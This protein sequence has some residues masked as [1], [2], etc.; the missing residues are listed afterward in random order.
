MN[1]SGP[2][3]PTNSMAIR[4][5]TCGTAEVADILFLVGESWS[6]GEGNF[7][8]IKDFVYSVILS[9]ENV[10]MGKEGVRLGVALY[11]EKPRMSIEL[12]D[13]V[14][15]EEVLVAVRELSF[16]GGSAKT[17]DALVFVAHVV[18]SPAAARGDAAKIVVLITD[19]KSADSVEDAALVLQDRGVTV[20]AVGIKNADRNE[21]RKIASMPAEEHVLYTEDFHLLGN[22]SPKLSRRLC[23]TASEPPRPT[24]QAVDVEK[25]VGPRDLLVSEQSYSSLRLT[26][27]PATGKVMEYHV[28]LNSL[29]ATGQLISEDQRQIVLDGNKSTMLVSDLKPD[30]NYFFTVL[31][32]YADALGEST[33]VKGK[34][35][36]IPPVTNF[37][38]IE[39]G[40]FSLKVAWTPP[41]GKLEGYKIYMPRSNRPGM[42]YEQ[43]LGRKVTSHVLGNLQEDKEYTVSIY[44]VYRQG[45][46]QP[47]SATGRTLKLL[48]V[49]SI[50]LQNETTDTIQARWT[51][52]RGASGYRLTWVSAGGSVE[53]VNLDD[54][55]TD[56]MIP[57]LQPGLEYTVTVNPVF[58]DVEGPVVSR[59][60]TTLAASAVQTLKV[61]DVTINSALLAWNSVAGATGYRVAWGPTP[62][63]FHKDRPRQLALNSSTTAYQ[64]RNLAPDSEYVISLYVLFG[65]AEGPGIT[66]SART[67]EY[68]HGAEA[69]PLLA[70]GAQVPGTYRQYRARQRALE[71][72]A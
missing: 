56:Y 31:A 29:S 24:R 51:S 23:V 43:I 30:T 70:R 60:A 67:C 15:I 19:G 16:Q 50:L 33:A 17:G 26:W 7:R 71:T 61:T 20:F 5:Q 62:E 59:K 9:F 37:R 36:P 14:T 21:L 12:T 1:P 64:L 3:S 8:L 48:P 41:L 65:S 58:G 49:K 6:V 28:L 22:L 45:S 55:C 54:T 4:R 69:V 63:F 46:S 39:E 32:V 52:V 35:T 38:V 34:T 72:H 11:A 68:T 53:T 57:G 18:F 2:R 42:T 25:I 13:Y 47:V 27:T 44:A 10:A 40:L 66:A